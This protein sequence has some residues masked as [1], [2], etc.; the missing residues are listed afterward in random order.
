MNS[1]KSDVD[2]IATLDFDDYNG[3]DNNS[4]E[5]D[6]EEG[7]VPM[8]NIK[9]SYATMCAMVKYSKMHTF[10]SLRPCYKHVE[11]K[12]Q[13]CRIKQYVNFQGTK[14]QKFQQIDEFVCIRELSLPIHDSDVRCQA[15]KRARSVNLPGFIAS[16]DWLYDFKHRHKISSRKTRNY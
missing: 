13:L 10:Q 2:N 14:V 8:N 15:I 1:S 9:H 12:E 6:N 7:S 4:E 11:H 3:D 5:A 16:H